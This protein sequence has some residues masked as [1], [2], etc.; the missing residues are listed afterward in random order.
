MN[1]RLKQIIQYET[2]GRQVAFAERMGWSSPYLNKLLKGVNF[3]LQPVLAILERFPEIDARWLLLG[4]GDM[5]S[6]KRRAELHREAFSYINGILSL[7][8]YLPYMSPEEVSRYE[9]AVVRHTT[10][11]FSEEQ[12]R[13]WDERRT[14]REKEIRDKFDEV[15]NSNNQEKKC[16]RQ[17][18]K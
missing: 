8:K 4:E 10:P 13:S 17:T 12:V 7:E 15:Y 18:A 2:G 11:D 5:L 14:L 6:Q 16:K 9:D 1:E 3:G